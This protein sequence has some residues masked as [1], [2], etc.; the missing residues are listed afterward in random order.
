MQLALFVGP[1]YSDLQGQTVDNTVTPPVVT[2]TAHQGWST[3]GGASFS[4]QGQ[5]T[6]ITASGV[7]KV[8][9]G[10]GLLQAVTL[11]T[12]SGAVRRQLARNTNLLF[13]GVYGNSTALEAGSSS[14][15]TVKSASGSVAWEQRFARNFTANLGYARDYQEQNVITLPTMNVNHNRGW[16]T[17]SYEFTHPLGN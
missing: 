9:D 11:I 1:E 8:S 3:A 6:S 4:W 16:I 2:P 13:S 15:T 7:R 14:F 12:G 17:L 10:G 5:R